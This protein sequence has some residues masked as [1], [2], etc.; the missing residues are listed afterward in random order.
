MTEVLF[1]S[2]QGQPLD[3]VL[4]TLLEKSLERG[5][6]RGAGRESASMPSMPSLWTY[7]EDGFLPHGSPRERGGRAA[8]C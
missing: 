4:P 5:W 8:R 6:R 1:T 7:R 2:L 3:R